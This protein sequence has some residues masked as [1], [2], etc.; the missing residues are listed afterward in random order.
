MDSRT[1]IGALA[2]LL[3]LTGIFVW[4]RAIGPRT[5]RV[6]THSRRLLFGAV[7]GALLGVGAALL[8]VDVFQLFGDYVL[9]MGLL[10]WVAVG[11][12]VLGLVCGGLA[13]LPRRRWWHHLTALGVVVCAFLVSGLGVNR[14]IGY[15]VNI[16]QVLSMLTTTDLPPLPEL[17]T[18]AAVD[19][20]DDWT[21]PTD[22]PETGKLVQVAIPANVSGFSARPTIVY[23]PPAALT[24]HP[25]RLPLLVTFSGQP[26]S[27]QDVFTSGH[28]HEILRGLPEGTPRDFTDRRV[29]GPTRKPTSQSDVFRFQVRAQ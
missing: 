14:E 11:T 26:G 12:A 5:R 21:P 9:T 4:Q 23:L 25:P 6:S 10:L 20:S 27:P 15:F 2:A 19:L 18:N 17:S 1:L 3:V 8:T 13:T 16:N 22:M 24:K 29:T 7:A 28:L